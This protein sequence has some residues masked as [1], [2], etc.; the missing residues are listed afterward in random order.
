M[1]NDYKCKNCSFKW[2]SPKKEYEK[3]PE[4]QSEDIHKID[5]E[6]IQETV[7][8]LTMGQR[9][10]YGG[11]GRGAGPPKV[12]KCTQCGYESPKTPGVPCRNA[13]CPECGAP[14]CGA[15]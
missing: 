13:N 4:C 8:Q 15:N 5:V 10:G 2:S 14:L 3:C 1:A 9:R 11:Q 7:G 12:C 6:E